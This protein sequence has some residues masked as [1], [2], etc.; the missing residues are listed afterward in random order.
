MIGG[1]IV[2]SVVAAFG[3]TLLRQ[4]LVSAETTSTLQE[5]LVANPSLV[6]ILGL[7]SVILIAPAE[8]LLFRG[9]I[10]NRLRSSFGPA[11]AIFGGSILFSGL[12]LLNFTGSL[13][14]A[15]LAAGVIGTVSLLWGYA[16]ERTGNFAVPV[17]THGL[18]N[19]T[20]MLITYVQ[21]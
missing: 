6:L 3:L 5:P 12:H 18:Y 8:E 7:L 10:Q 16:Y 13:L 17:L 19:L 9:A 1:G 20:L 14:G 4:R 15:L 21:L 2:A 11:G